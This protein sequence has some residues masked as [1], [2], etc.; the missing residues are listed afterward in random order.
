MKS[1]EHCTHE[2]KTTVPVEAVDRLESRLHIPQATSEE[3]HRV[4]TQLAIHSNTSPNQ[5]GTRRG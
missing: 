3:E 5:H 2:I 4:D 1:R